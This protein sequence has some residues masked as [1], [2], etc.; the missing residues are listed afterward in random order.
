[1]PRD[2]AKAAVGIALEATQGF[3]ES[4]LYEEGTSNTFKAEN[5][6][7]RTVVLGE[8]TESSAVDG[9]ENL[10]VGRQETRALGWAVQGSSEP[11]Q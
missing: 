10:E 4:A 2:R 7:V 5:R 11:A 9:E 1:M 3:L 6:L 8:Q